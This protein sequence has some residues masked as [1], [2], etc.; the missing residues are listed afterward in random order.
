MTGSYELFVFLV[1]LVFLVFLVLFFS[2][3]ARLY[4]SHAEKNR[5]SSYVL[6]KKELRGRMAEALLSPTYLVCLLLFVIVT[7]GVNS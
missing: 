4:A 7:L 5:D 6:P 2:E 3:A 1:A